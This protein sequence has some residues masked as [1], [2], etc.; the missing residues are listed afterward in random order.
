MRFTH[1]SHGLALMS[2]T[3]Y[4][5][6]LT[7]NIWKTDLDALLHPKEGPMIAKPIGSTTG[8]LEGLINPG[9]PMIISG[10][11]MRLEFVNYALALFIFSV[12]HAQVFW[13]THKI[14]AVLLGVQQVG[15]TVHAMFSF[16][17][18]SL[19]YKVHATGIYGTVKTKLPFLLNHHVSLLLFIISATIIFLSPMILYHFGYLRFSSFVKD[20]VR[21]QY[22]TCSEQSSS[23]GYVVIIFPFNYSAQLTRNSEDIFNNDGSPFFL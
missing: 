18:F 17:G 8:E 20:K 1:H 2:S 16:T 10:D 11:G 21:R 5:Y 13:H 6:T 7:E 3:G 4:L 23:Y 12:R 9:F 15:N 14:L 19:L 22:V